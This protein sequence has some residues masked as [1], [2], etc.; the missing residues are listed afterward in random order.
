M[1]MI[2]QETSFREWR[3]VVQEIVRFINAEKSFSN[4]RPLRYCAM[5]DTHPDSLP[6][7]ARFHAKKILKL[8]DAVL[9]SYHQNEVNYLFVS[10]P[11][12]LEI[13]SYVY[14]CVS[15]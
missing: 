4:A 3:Q 7:V 5:F 11:R 2:F 9:T 13:S 6:Y 8:K 15:G 10:F 12:I 14:V 1:K